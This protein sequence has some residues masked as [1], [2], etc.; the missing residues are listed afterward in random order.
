MTAE[1]RI[2]I[3]ENVPI[4]EAVRRQVVPAVISQM[5]ALIYNLAD[6][7]FVGL[8]NA[9]VETAA[10]TVAYA[11][12]LMLTAIANL[13]G[14]GGAGALSRALGVH[15]DRAAG[16]I[17]ALSFWCG[18]ASA[19]AYSLL[20]LLLASPILRLAGATGET[21]NAA[22]GYSKWVIVIGGIP[23]ALNVLLSNLVRAEGNAKTAS[24]G[25]SLGGIMN[26]LLDPLLILP[27]F[28]GLSAVG[29][30][31]ATAIS[32]LIAALYLLW[33]IVG[34]QDRSVVRLSP[35]LL[36]GRGNHLQTILSI[37]IP[38]ALQ[39]ALTVVAVAAQAKFVSQYPTQAVAALGITKKLDQLPLYFSIGVS[40]GLLPL[41]A[42]HHAAG[43]QKRR[44]EA[45]R[46]GLFIS[47]AFSLFC[48]IFYEAMSPQLA[49]LFIRDADTVRYAAA[50]LRR[51]VTTM[52]LMSI[53]YPMIIQFQAMKRARES[54]VCSVLRKGVLDVP[55]LFAMDALFPLYGLMWVQPIVDAVSLIVCVLFYRNL[56]KQNLA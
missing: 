8:L 14:V 16:K 21:L 10:V 32:N 39:Y 43:N 30:G 40:A 13:F 22:L 51:M 37:G 45:F 29:A 24:F 55:L 38:S 25:V 11:P 3:F 31:I 4:S 23:S 20:F 46:R 2:R 52:P 15:D 17:S 49:S 42:Y 48:L 28:A 9:P 44:R 5:I 6:T 41:L 19:G 18:F 53:C 36:H 47:F 50:F 35:K 1:E 33:F 27:Q 12:F 34:R 7:Y 56:K 54:L 26:I